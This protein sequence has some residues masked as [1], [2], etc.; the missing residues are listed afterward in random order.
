MLFGRYEVMRIDAWGCRTFFVLACPSVHGLIDEVV[1]VKVLQDIKIRPHVFDGAVTIDDVPVNMFHALIEGVSRV[2][3]VLRRSEFDFIAEPTSATFREPSLKMLLYNMLHPG[4][5]FMTME[6]RIASA[7]PYK[8]TEQHQLSF[9]QVL[10]GQLRKRKI[11][12]WVCR[13]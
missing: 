11:G 7:Q 9:I 4:P 2:A 10:F 1:P 3:I 5:E 13:C 8:F 12:A 6:R